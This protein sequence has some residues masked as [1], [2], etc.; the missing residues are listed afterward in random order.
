MGPY[1]D[2]R[3]MNAFGISKSYFITGLTDDESYLFVM[4]TASFTRSNEG[5][6][7]PNYFEGKEVRILGLMNYEG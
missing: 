2:E 7:F 4:G 6:Y 1:M 3:M 5:V